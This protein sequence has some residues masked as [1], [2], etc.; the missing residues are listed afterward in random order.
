MNCLSPEYGPPLAGQDL[1]AA[2]STLVV[3]A[4]R[5]YRKIGR[6]GDA[7]VSDHEV[8]RSKGSSP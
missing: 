6:L 4:L 3:L 1:R 8:Y 7:T 5:L 2:R